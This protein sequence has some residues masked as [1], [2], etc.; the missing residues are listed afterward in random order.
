MEKAKTFISKNR[1]AV[2]TVATLGIAGA[3]S[4]YFYKQ[5]KNP[6]NK[7][8]ETV[9]GSQILRAGTRAKRIISEKEL[10]DVIESIKKG[11]NADL[12]VLRAKY[13]EER[14]KV[15]YDDEAYE[16]LIDEYDSKLLQILQETSE[17]VFSK[18][19]ISQAIFDDSVKYYVDDEEISLAAGSIA[20]VDEDFNISDI[21]SH[22]NKDLL[23]DIFNFYNKRYNEA[24]FDSQK[25]IEYLTTRIQDE[26][27]FQYKI[28]M[29]EFTSYYKLLNCENDQDFQPK[30]DEI[31]K[32]VTKYITSSD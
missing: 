31:H 16:A 22:I 13:R 19:R 3:L 20:T 27:Y 9:S 5:R 23:L 12:K 25:N 2:I 4:V 21:P 1:V 14:R 30:V 15:F 26:I 18:Y 24:I 8:R 32:S 6:E 11:C 29:E 17:N 28:E 7:K 10:L